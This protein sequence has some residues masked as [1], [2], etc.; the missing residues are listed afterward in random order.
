MFDNFKKEYYGFNSLVGGTQVNFL[1]F[2]TLFP[3]LVLDVRR[4]SERLKTGVVDLVLKFVFKEVVPA[5]TMIYVTTVSDRQYKLM[6][7][8]S[9]I[10]LVSK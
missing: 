3:S 9:N 2:K 8:G 5:N 4:Q 7:D 10:S 6:S 1:T